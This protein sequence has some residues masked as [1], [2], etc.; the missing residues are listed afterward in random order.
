[1]RRASSKDSEL[2]AQDEDLDLSLLVSA[3]VRSTTQ[4]R[5]LVTIT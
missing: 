1:M 5:S 2:V 4:P 3:R